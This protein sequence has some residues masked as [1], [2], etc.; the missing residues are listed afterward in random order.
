MPA[1][2]EHE[3]DTGPATTT[4]TTTASVTASR[5]PRRATTPTRPC[6]RT[7]DPAGGVLTDGTHRPHR[8]GVLVAPVPAPAPR[9]AA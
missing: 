7:R 9:R 1:P 4:A 2:H 8:E 5:A 6:P 3:P